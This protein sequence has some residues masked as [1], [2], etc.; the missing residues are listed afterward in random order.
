MPSFDT[1]E[2]AC[3]SRE[4]KTVLILAIAVIGCGGP[5]RP[6]PVAPG[7]EI[8]RMGAMNQKHNMHG[9]KGPMGAMGAMSSTDDQGEDQEMGEANL[10]PQV[11]AFHDV[12]A[13][14][15][16]APHGAKRIADTCA[17]VPQF[18]SNAEAIA[19]AQPP[20]GGDAAAWSIG[21]KQLVEAV[22]GLETPCKANDASGFEPAFERVHTAFHQVMAAADGRHEEHGTEEQEHSH[23]HVH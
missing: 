20:G 6:D 5:A 9:S 2:R 8:G 21:V 12:L 4:M 7:G 23:D 1:R 17:A 22:A 10:P 11:A 19:T 3:E 18:R 14:R 15:W 13:P 16:H